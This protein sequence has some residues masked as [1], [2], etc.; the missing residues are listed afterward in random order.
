MA[1]RKE[2]EIDARAVLY[3][4]AREF[5]L[6]RDSFDERLKLQKV[7]YLLQAFGVQLG[8]GFGWYKYGPYSQDLVSDAYAVLGSRKSEYE[9]AASEGEWKFS[10]DTLARF[11]QFKS[12]CGEYL[13]SAEKAELLASV[14]FVNNVW[15]PDIDNTDAFV[16]EFFTRKPRLCNGERV[17]RE[18]VEQALEVCRKLA[19]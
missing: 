14:R 12:F 2:M 16:T 11:R 13:G 6:K 5:Q 10:P 7:V 4:V 17:K 9:R 3:M 15:C 8:Y 1:G 18:D 19:G